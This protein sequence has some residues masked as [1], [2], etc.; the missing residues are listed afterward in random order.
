MSFSSDRLA[1]LRHL[2]QINEG[3]GF[4]IPRTDA[5]QNEQVSP[6]D[7]RLLWL[8]N[9]TG[10]AGMAIVLKD[11]AAL[12]VDGRYTLQAQHQVDLND[13]AIYPSTDSALFQWFEQNLHSGQKIF[14]DPWFHTFRDQTRFQ[15]VCEATGASFVPL[16]QNFIDVLWEDRPASSLQPAYLYEERYAGTSYAEKCHLVSQNLKAQNVD[17]AL[18]SAPESMAWLLNVRGN[19]I[20]YTPIPLG[21]CVIW[22]DGS[23]DI[24]MGA[25][26]IPEDVKHYWGA[27]VRCHLLE[28]LENWLENLDD[29]NVLA[30]P[31]RTPLALLQKLEN[32][33]VKYHSDPCE[34]PKAIKNQIEIKGARQAHHQDG[35]AVVRFLSWLSQ[36]IKHKALTEIEAAEKLLFFRQQNALFKDMS[37]ATI[38][39]VG[40]NASIVHYHPTPSTNHSFEKESIY[41]V[42]SGGQYMGGTTDITRTV[43]VGLPSQ[44]QKE[45]FTLV[46]KGHIALASALFPIG[47]T[48]AQLD[49]LARYPLWQV[50]LDYDHGTGHGVGSYLSVHEGPQRIGKGPS[51]IVLQPGMIISNEPGYYKANDYGIRIESLVLVVDK[52]TPLG[53]ERPL[54]GFETLTQAPIDKTLID[55]EMLTDQEREW[56]NQYHE[57]VRRTLLPFLDNEEAHWLIQATEPL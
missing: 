6:S 33:S 9:F 34:L 21:F 20:P 17:V 15:R 18:I 51:S 42:D 35:L 36:Q 32:C 4:L 26:K 46:L 57:Q 11:A 49:I 2:I 37:F 47:T 41:L 53:G 8:T 30:D 50:G 29:L 10:S 12:F 23:V 52:G 45:R 24:F 25:G 44:E 19:D 28:S 56:L 5:Y 38:S 1:A 40:P 54:L 27:N 16:A 3:D 55:D 43:S 7:E 22:V 48:G 31:H 14:Y 39:A 13:Y